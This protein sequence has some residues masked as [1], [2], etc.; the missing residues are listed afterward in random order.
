MARR[1]VRYGPPAPRPACRSA[2]TRTR[3]SSARRRP[4]SHRR[5]RRGRV[6]RRPTRSPDR[7]PRKRRRPPRP[8]TACTRGCDRHRLPAKRFRAAD[9]H[10]DH[11]QDGCY[12]DAADH[13]Q[14]V[15]LGDAEIERV[16][17]TLEDQGVA[18]VETSLRLDRTA[19]A[20]GDPAHGDAVIGAAPGRT[21]ER[22][23]PPSARG[24][25]DVDVRAGRPGWEQS[26]VGLGERQR[27][28]IGGNEFAFGD[29]RG[30]C[31]SHR[32]HPG[33][34][35]PRGQGESAEQRAHTPQRRGEAIVVA[36]AVQVGWPTRSRC[37]LLPNVEARQQ[38]D[39]RRA[40]SAHR[41]ADP[42]FRGDR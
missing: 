17:G 3:P 35:P 37:S 21:A 29:H 15:V 6:R 24:Q 9:S 23:L 42:G 7:A 25:R 32:P 10:L 38:P 20:I 33:R 40:D 28:D 30:L 22:I 14:R 1:H 41:V 36:P 2:R 34:R 11:R 12:A 18:Y 26:A 39:H 16:A 5:W 13:E 19:A 31:P 4:A 27:N 8:G